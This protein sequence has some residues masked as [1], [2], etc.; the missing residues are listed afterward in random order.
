V[1][2]WIIVAILIG[3]LILAVYVPLRV[4]AAE[5]MEDAISDANDQ[6]DALLQEPSTSDATLGAV[7]IGSPM[8]I[9][10]PVNAS[11]SSNRS[12]SVG[13]APP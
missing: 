5:E 9:Q 11:I 10:P 13:I 2:V 1:N 4:F 8:N 6:L 3:G 12:D 7:N